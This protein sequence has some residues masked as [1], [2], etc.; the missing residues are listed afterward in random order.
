MVLDG[1][2]LAPAL[3][4]LVFQYLGFIFDIHLCSVLPA[5]SQLSQFEIDAAADE[6]NQQVSLRPGT[7]VALFHLLFNFL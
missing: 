3:I 6:D 2:S 7:E 4:N 1:L 5:P